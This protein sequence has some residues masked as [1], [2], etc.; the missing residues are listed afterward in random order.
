MGTFSVGNRLE[1]LR[2]SVAPERG[3]PEP[4]YVDVQAQM[5][6]LWAES[7][8]ML[9]DRLDILERESWRWARDPDNRAAGLIV[10]DLAH[11]MAGVL[12]TFG[13]KRGSMVASSIERIVGM[14]RHTRGAAGKTIYALVTE[15]REIV[16]SR[17]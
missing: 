12:G 14:P 17:H 13:M 2:P 7:R 8:P 6:A 1:E 11:K 4:G 3:Y 15:L 9:L 5:N 16:K 10:R